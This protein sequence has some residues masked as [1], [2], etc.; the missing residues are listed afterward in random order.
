MRLRDN[1]GNLIPDNN[2]TQNQFGDLIQ[3]KRSFVKN[4][5]KLDVPHMYRK[6]GIHGN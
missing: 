6:V 1:E 5:I 4:P 2:Y 3:I